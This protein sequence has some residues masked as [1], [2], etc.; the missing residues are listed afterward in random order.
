MGARAVKQG[1]TVEKAETQAVDPR[2]RAGKLEALTVEQ[3]PWMVGQ[4]TRAMQPG[5][6]TGSPELGWM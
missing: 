2:I 5:F 1:G 4:W 3:W 6:G